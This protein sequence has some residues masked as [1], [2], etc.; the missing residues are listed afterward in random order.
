M[1]SIEPLRCFATT[2][3]GVEAWTADELRG[4]GVTVNG[5][6][7]GG[8]EFTASTEQLAEALLWLRTA[9]RV[10]V[11]L[12]SFRARTF[13]E[14][15]RH[16][17]QV[18]WASVI[19][20]GIAVH[21]RVTSIKSRLYHQGG[22]AER[23]ERSVL[24]AVAGTTAMR[25]PADTEALERD[26]TVVPAVQRI[27]V[28]VL[29]DEFTLSADACGALLHRRG[30]RQAVA[31]AP[32]RE[33]LAAALLLACD[34]TP[35]LPLA[36]PMCGSGTIPIEA[37]MIARKIAPG[38]ARRFAAERWRDWPNLCAAARAGA[39]ARALPASPRPI[40][41]Y[42]RDA[43][44]VTASR[45]NAARAGVA[46]DIDFRTQAV[47]RLAA[48]DGA[49]WLVVNPP[50]GAR[51]GDRGKLRDVYATLGQVQRR[52]RPAW[53]LAMLSASPVLDTQVGV[54]W[55]ELFRTNN[56]GIPIRAVSS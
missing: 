29:R 16:A 2:A 46:D 32:L 6:E 18:D 40:A 13:A 14:L 42:D 30:Y 52:E 26:V 33:T 41:G 37:A 4:L 51:I 50:Y 55:R 27:V 9:N 31:K 7:P 45:A 47:S 54:Q 23:L 1:P 21:F 36:D 39:H 28:R 34:W 49:G 10:T 20:P 22:I 17:A 43:G 35:D 11:R 24:A 48:D 5:Q 56:G 53:H 25:A 38:A 19:E 8:V 3:P 44:A 15:E 12:A